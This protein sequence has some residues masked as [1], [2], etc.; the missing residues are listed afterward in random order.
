MHDLV[1]KTQNISF[2]NKA[3]ANNSSLSYINSVKKYREFLSTKNLIEN[4]DSIQAFFVD[5]R[6]RVSSATF[7][8]V[9][10]GLKSYLMDKNKDDFRQLFGIQEVFKSIRKPKVD[11][12]INESKFITY[13]EF[14]KF[15]DKIQF[16]FNLIFQFLFW[17]GTRISGALQVSL[18]DITPVRGKSYC[19][20]R[21]RHGKGDKEHFSYIPKDLAKKING[22]KGKKYLFESR[23]GK[24]FCRKHIHLV[25]TTFGEKAGKKI[26]PHTLRHSRAMM[27][28]DVKKLS[29]DQ[30]GKFLNHS[31]VATTL[32]YYFHGTPSAEDVME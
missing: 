27:L 2:K 23:P 22:L 6:H 13:K 8:N 26:T 21:L 31:D 17:T 18:S 10:Y 19:V 9:I 32:R 14:L 28:K 20:V 24:A 12:K 1:I 4:S 25:F 15:Q 11:Y 16:P 3:L 29:P 7:N 30:I 5:L